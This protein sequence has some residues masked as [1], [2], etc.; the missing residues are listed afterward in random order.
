M[1]SAGRE[2]GPFEVGADFQCA[3]ILQGKAS[4]PLHPPEMTFSQLIKHVIKVTH[5]QVVGMLSKK[6]YVASYSPE[7]IILNSLTFCLGFSFIIPNNVPTE[8]CIYA[9]KRLPPDAWF[10]LRRRF[11][12]SPRLPRA[13]QAV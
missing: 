3:S 7:M 1:A 6:Y 11:S 10:W 13:L 5:S 2:A 12:W 8:L 4:C 9:F